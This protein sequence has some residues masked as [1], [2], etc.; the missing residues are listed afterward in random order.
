MKL[1]KLLACLT[2]TLLMSLP[3]KAADITV[4]AAASLSNVLKKIGDAYNQTSTDKVVFNFASSN[5]LEAQIKA[6]TPA[7]IFFSA[8]EA[9]MDE[10]DKQGLLAKGSRKDFLSNSLII[11]VPVESNFPFTTPDQLADPSFK[12]IALGQTESV[13]AGIYARQYLTKLGI[14]DKVSTRVVP[15]ENVRAAYE[16]VETGNVD[17]A[18]AYKTDAFNSKK[19]KVAYEVPIAEGPAITYPVAILAGTKNSVAAKKFFDYL[20][21]PVSLQLFQAR[22]FIIKP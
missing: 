2:L 10:L 12:K 6:G 14:W 1:P 5:T 17:A 9:K 7:D 20:S 11:I 18:I 22:G 21:N 15:C 13:P 16:A 19:V 4:F 8:D 3:T